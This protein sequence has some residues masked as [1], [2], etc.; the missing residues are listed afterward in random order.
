MTRFTMDDGLSKGKFQD[1]GPDADQAFSIQS[2]PTDR[3]TSDG[4][5]SREH[6]S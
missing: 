6:D 4:L 3:D 5:L 1:A 2:R